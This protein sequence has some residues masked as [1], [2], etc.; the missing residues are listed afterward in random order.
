MSRI[1]A[2]GS[3]AVKEIVESVNTNADGVAAAN[4][5]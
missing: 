1:F 4:T 2:E 5:I 3:G